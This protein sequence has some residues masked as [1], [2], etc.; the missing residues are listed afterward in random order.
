MAAIDLVNGKVPPWVAPMVAVARPLAATLL[1]FIPT[2]GAFTVG[3]IAAFSFDRAMNMAKAA[4]A[5][6]H[7][8]P[9][10]AYQVIAAVSIGY[11][12]FKTVEA[13][14]GKPPN[15]SPEAELLEESF[16]HAPAPRPRASAPMP[17]APNPYVAGIDP[18]NAPP[19]PKR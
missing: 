15:P 14:K 18:E 2:V 1:I 19:R 4:S 6:L 3:T 11:A 9:D 12:G 8:I 13:V 10:P 5:F 16:G 17:S 7:G